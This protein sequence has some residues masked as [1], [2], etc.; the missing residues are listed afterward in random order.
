MTPPL[1]DGALD[2]VMRAEIIARTGAAERSLL[3]SDA[4][5]ADEVF[6]SNSLGLQAVV[7]LDGTPIGTGTPGRQ[8]LA[9]ASLLG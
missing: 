7:Q 3:L 2:G 8:Y 9:L 4:A 5:G 6:L 1:E